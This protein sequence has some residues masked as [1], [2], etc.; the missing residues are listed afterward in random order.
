MASTLAQQADE[1]FGITLSP[2]QTAQFAQ[3]AEVLAA[4]NA[5][6][7]LTAITEPAAVQV[8]HFLDSLSIAQ[9]VPMRSGLR[10]IDVGTGAGFPGLPLLIAFPH[11]RVTLLEATGKKVNFLDH[12]IAQLGLRGAQTLHARA[13]EAG[14]MPDQRAAYDLVLARAVARLPA[15][16]EYLLPLARIGGQCIAM[17]GDTAADEARDAARAIDLMGGRFN[18]IETIE[19]PDIDEPHRLVI[20]DKVAHT[21]RTYPRK[22]GTPTHVPL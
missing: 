9:V 5:H 22:P 16:V 20:I 8:R 13:E 14:H 10:L 4:W 17:K 7:N 21:P 2:E 6:T 1:Q 12:V 11:I 15:L 3:Y 19:L 18:R